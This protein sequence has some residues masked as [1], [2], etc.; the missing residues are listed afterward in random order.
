MP[1]GTSHILVSHPE[2]PFI[3]KWINVSGNAVDNL[4]NT[5]GIFAPAVFTGVDTQGLIES[6]HSTLSSSLEPQEVVSSSVLLLTAIVHACVLPTLPQADAQN[7]VAQMI[8]T[9]IDHHIQDHD[10]SVSKV[11]DMLSMPLF[12]VTKV[13]QQAYGI[14]PHTYITHKRINNSKLLLR[15]TT[16]P[17]KTI[18]ETMGFTDSTYFFHFF[19]KHTG[20]SPSKF[21]KCEGQHLSDNAD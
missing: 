16:L 19:K 4:L 8:K 21:R 13:F 14:G 15:S 5:Y 20:V 9:C 3:A 11:A 6:Y 17:I 18:A 1:A 12:K 10:L 7:R 2:R